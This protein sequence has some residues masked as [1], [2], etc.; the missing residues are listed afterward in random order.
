MHHHA[1]EA[2]RRATCQFLRERVNGWSLESV[3][4]SVLLRSGRVIGQQFVCGHWKIHW[5]AG[6]SNL[7]VFDGEREPYSIEIA[8]PQGDQKAA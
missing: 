6:Q 5:L 7:R 4:E 1:L 2:A 8:M 3:S